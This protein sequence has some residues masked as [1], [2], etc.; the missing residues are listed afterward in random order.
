MQNDAMI[1]AAFSPTTAR[2]AWRVFTEFLNAVGD[3]A[4]RG[5]IRGNETSVTSL[6]PLLE[7]TFHELQESGNLETIQEIVALEELEDDWDSEG[8]CAA[9]HS[10]GELAL[11]LVQQAYIAAA[12]QARCGR[13]PAVSTSGD[14]GIALSWS[15]ANRSALV[16]IRPSS[17]NDAVCVT[18]EDSHAPVRAVRSQEETV[19]IIC[20]ALGDA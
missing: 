4:L 12:A 20:W 9:T 6:S 13:R 2:T 3:A 14:G 8:G 11:K 18:Q 5:A 10:A 15:D 16:I 19:R 7:R 1:P 17:S